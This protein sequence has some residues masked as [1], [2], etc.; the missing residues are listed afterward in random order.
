M[1]IRIQARTI[2]CGEVRMICVQRNPYMLYR[3]LCS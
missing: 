1:T 3:A 2:G